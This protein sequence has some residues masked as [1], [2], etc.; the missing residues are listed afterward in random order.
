MRFG[1]IILSFCFCCF[2]FEANGQAVFTARGTIYKKS[3]PEKLAGVSVTN[4][5]TKN[6]STSDN[7]GVFNIPALIGDT[8]LF[9]KL[10]FAA[11]TYVITSAFDVNI[12]LPPMVIL[13]EVTVKE[14]T[15]KQEVRE[16]M[17]NYRKAGGYYTLTPSPWSAINSPVTAIYEE[18]GTDPNRARK[19]QEHTQEELERIE[20]F[21]RYNKP[22][23]K[24][25]TGLTDDKEIQKFTDVF[26]PSYEDM[27][28]WS[29]YE[30][31]NYIKISFEWYKTHQDEFK[32]RVLN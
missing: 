23:V 4:L 26:T 10:N 21:K 31:V 6:Q 12:Y 15:K 8:L 20:I 14:Q 5:R 29:D 28:S 13:N 9:N 27:K 32:A 30:V 7:W 19:F 24:K 1:Y 3:T 11:Q 18:L 2:V 16:T 25:V 22:L 17:D